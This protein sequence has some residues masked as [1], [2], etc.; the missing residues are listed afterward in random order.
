MQLFE[1]IRDFYHP[2][3]RQRF[4]ALL[5]D[6][7]VVVDHREATR[8]NAYFPGFSH[9]CSINHAGQRVGYLRFGISPLEDR[10]YL[11]EIEVDREHRRKGIGL[12]TVWWLWNTYQVPVITVQ[13]RGTS[14]GFWSKSTTRFAAIGAVVGD[15]L[16]T[17]E[18][19][20]EKQRWQH[21]VPEPE[22]LQFQ[23]AAEAEPDFHDRAA[24]WAE[25][26]AARQQP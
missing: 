5:P 22:H 20:V 7:Q 24:A 9:W 2:L 15:E 17:A 23:R 18:L 11:D 12:A 16:R 10:V 13:Q 8:G 3:A 1:P 14:N 6:M 4:T 19:N 26:W 21:L 25:T